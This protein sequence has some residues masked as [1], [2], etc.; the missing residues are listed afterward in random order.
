[1]EY[2]SA[3]ISEL[4]ESATL[5]MAALT[6][7]LKG[8]GKEIIDMSLGEP[9]F[10]TPQAIKDAAIK[11]I[12]EGYTKYPPVAGYAELRSKIAH[13][14]RRD[15]E[16]EFQPDQIVVSTGA[17]QSLMNVLLCLVN[18]GD[19]VIVPAPYWVSYA[20]MVQLA[21]GKMITIFA[22]VNQDFKITPTQL[23]SAITNKTKAFLFSSPSNP[24]GTFYSKAEL[25]A[26]A[27][28]FAQY[29]NVFIIS[30]EIYEY[31]NFSGKHE[32]IAQFD[33]IKDRVIVVNGFSKG[34]AMTGWRLGYIAAPLAI[35]KACVKLQG[36]FTSGT[37]S[38]AQKA[39]EAAISGSLEPTYAMRDTFLVRRNLIISRL[40]A[41]PGFTVSLPEG[42]FYV[43]PDISY[44]FGKKHDDIIIKNAEDFAMFILSEANVAIVAGDAFGN[45]KCVR[46]SYATSTENIEKAI[47]QIA[48]SL[49]LLN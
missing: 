37:C 48:Q 4:E 10:D 2:L 8:Q 16:L 9:D 7:E 40:K 29:P 11:A 45:E 15:N 39:A 26:L 31:I 47:Q 24:S 42:A 21:E 17:K 27:E 38:I 1:M 46:L 43:F 5:K 6:R 14:L 33:A 3:R 32:S 23:K 36:Q 30:D 35:A 25:A 22:D 20:A 13:K 34:F 28:V 49:K 12:L 19:E 44:Y 41:L 18:P